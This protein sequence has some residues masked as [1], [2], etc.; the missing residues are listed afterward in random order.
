M[1]QARLLTPE[2]AFDATFEAAF[3]AALEAAR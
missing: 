2:M 1:H 3:E